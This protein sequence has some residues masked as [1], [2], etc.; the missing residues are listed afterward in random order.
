M[1]TN[2]TLDFVV[3]KNSTKII[4]VIGIGGGGVNAVDFM[5]RK[6]IH[7]VNFAAVNTD[8]Q[9]FDD[10]SIPVK[11]TLGDGFGAGSDPEKAKLKFSQST[12]EVAKLLDDGTKMVFISAAMGGGTG[13]GAAPLLAQ[14]AKE[15]GI[16]TVG[17]VTLPFSFEML[18]RIINALDAVEEMSRQVDALIVIN[19]DSLGSLEGVKALEGFDKPNEILLM[20]VKSIAEIITVKGRINRDF[21]DITTTMK[22]SGIAF[23]SYGFGSGPN[24]IDDAINE[25]M[26]SSLLN[27][28]DVNNA[29]RVLYY[30]SVHENSPVE[31]IELNEQMT[32]FMGRFDSHIIMN[33]G[34]GVDKSL[35]EDKEVKFTIIA[36]GFG[37]DAV[38]ELKKQMMDKHGTIIT[39]TIAQHKNEIKRAEAAGFNVPHNQKIPVAPLSSMVVMTSDELDN[40]EL[41]KY[42]EA[43]PPYLR[44]SNEIAALRKPATVSFVEVKDE[45]SASQTL[46]SE[47]ASKK[48]TIKFTV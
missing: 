47:S 12:A 9:S 26:Y 6:G 45:S 38:P 43:H 14:M 30:V 16:L 18:P 44:L 4:K 24:R 42:L 39:D 7:G 8:A 2:V 10:L 17:V 29:Q 28:N 5:C 37:I 15:R 40:E 25:A 20:A 34:F 22:D 35:P 3:Q 23:V 31:I 1:D 13:T 11:V 21:E 27:N 41:I 33:W 32:K 46:T 48:K 19:N 36:T